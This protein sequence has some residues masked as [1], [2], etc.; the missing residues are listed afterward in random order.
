MIETKEMATTTAKPKEAT[1]VATI[2]AFAQ[3]VNP[4][5][6]IEEDV[7]WQKML[8]SYEDGSKG[9]KIEVEL[10]NSISVSNQFLMPLL[11]VGLIKHHTLI[12]LGTLIHAT[13]LHNKLTNV[14]VVQPI[15][16]HMVDNLSI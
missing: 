16:I 11:A 3:E 1:T 15:I 6:K 12:N 8:D 13:L 10:V 5:V 4:I 9:V 14:C 2:A 7:N